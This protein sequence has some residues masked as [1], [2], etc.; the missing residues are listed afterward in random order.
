MEVSA[1][2]DAMTAASEQFARA[3]SA[4]GDVEL[5][6]QRAS[7]LAAEATG[8]AQASAGVVRFCDH[9]TAVMDDTCGRLLNVASGLRTA[10][11]VVWTAGGGGPSA[12]AR[13]QPPRPGRPW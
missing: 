10:L 2:Y 13:E 3:F 11:E 4:L 6:V 1:R 9:V 8:D 12:S 5:A 7:T